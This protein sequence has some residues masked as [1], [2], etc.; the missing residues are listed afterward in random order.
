MGFFREIYKSAFRPSELKA[1]MMI[2]LESDKFAPPK[3][4][5]RELAGELNDRDFAYAALSKVSRSFAVVIRQL[6]TGLKDAVCAFYLILRALDTIEDD[7]SVPDD[8]KI[9]LLL[10]FYNKTEIDG[11]TLEGI[12]D[13]EDYRV[14]LENYD[15]IIR[16]YKSLDKPYRDTISHACM[17]MGKGMAE[18]SE[19]EMV[20]IDDFD[21]YCYYVAGLVGIGLSDLFYHSGL[22]SKVIAD[23]KDWSNSMG[24]FLQKTNI[25]RDYH[26]DL[27]AD[28]TFWP[29][30]VWSMYAENLEDF[31]ANPESADALNCLGLMVLDALRHIPDCLDYLSEIRD[32]Q[33]LRFTAIPQIMAIATLAEV[34]N[35]VEVF[36]GVVKIRKGMAAR[37]MT[38][39]LTIDDVY[40]Y[41]SRY[42]KKLLNKTTPYADHYHETRFL[43][44]KIRL[45]IQNRRKAL[46]AAKNITNEQ[47]V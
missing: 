47:P 34:Y 41:F 14:L 37:V 33:V 5:L 38:S 8:E 9:P 26:E 15:K 39:D 27:Y 24:L 29:K 3:Q 10:D 32:A 13:Q 36:K 17:E 30:E 12:G 4:P 7:M 45:D 6:P 35:N 1:L 11:F 19:K 40:L 43:V 16:F 20:S 22:E 28:R 21:Q 25:I 31:A 23:R 2:K 44:N 42:L 18:F 46:R